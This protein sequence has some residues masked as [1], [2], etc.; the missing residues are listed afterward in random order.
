MAIN[1]KSFKKLF[2]NLYREIEELDE[3]KVPINAVRADPEA[4]EK[5]AEGE[6]EILEPTELPDKFRHFNPSA[7]DFIRRCDTEKQAEEIVNYLQNKGEIS[8]EYAQELKDKLKC[9]GVRSFGPK[10]EENYYF[11][12]S[13]IY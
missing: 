12:E 4:A 8:A 6:E 13:G 1:K 9:Q 10:K 5:A 11:H 2:P 7:I 3:C